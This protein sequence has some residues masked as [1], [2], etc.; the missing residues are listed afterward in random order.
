[1]D[2][3]QKVHSIPGFVAFAGGAGAAVQPCVHPH[4]DGTQQKGCRGGSSMAI[5]CPLQT[6]DGCYC[7]RCWM[8]SVFF[9]NCKNAEKG[10]IW[11]TELRLVHL[12]NGKS[13]GNKAY[14]S[15]NHCRSYSRT[16]K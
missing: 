1:M 3:A 4:D 10:T 7:T 8:L 13:V 2:L 6:V 11:A 14:A 12:I 9:L 16:R 15:T 5:L